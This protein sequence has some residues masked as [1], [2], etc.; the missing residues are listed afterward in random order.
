MYWDS[1]DSS[2]YDSDGYYHNGR[3]NSDSDDSDYSSSDSSSDEIAP[4]REAP[5]TNQ[6]R[7][8]QTRTTQQRRIYTNAADVVYHE[9]PGMNNPNNYDEFSQ[10]EIREYNSLMEQIEMG[11]TTLSDEIP[12]LSEHLDSLHWKV[13]IKVFNKLHSRNYDVVGMRYQMLLSN[14]VSR[15][16]K[17]THPVMYDIQL[18]TLKE[19]L[20]RRE[21]NNLT[22]YP[23]DIYGPN[24]ID[25][26][27]HCCI[28][29]NTRYLINLCDKYMPKDCVAR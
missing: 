15:Y 14:G 12:S 13:W 17:V 10:Q 24:F 4:R 8:T 5:R 19:Y 22:K 2:D 25:I 3:S 28:D 27:N 11:M 6:T 21:A 1:S 23:W 20:R 7:T 9:Q 18:K 29:G 16:Y 26:F